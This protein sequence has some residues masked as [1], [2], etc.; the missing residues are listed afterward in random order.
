VTDIF[1]IVISVVAFLIILIVIIKSKH[2]LDETKSMVNLGNFFLELLIIEPF[3]FFIRWVPG[4]WGI[5]LR[6]V[7]YKFLFKEMGK[8]V[9]IMEGSKIFDFKNIEIGE[10]SSLNEYCYLI[11]NGSIKIGSWTRIASYVSLITVD[12]V[13]TDP[14]VKI[15]K[16]GL[17]SAP[18]VIGDDVWIGTKAT[19]LKGI[20]IGNG[21]VIGA[22]SVVTD[23]IPSFA[24]VAGVPAKII[25]LRSKP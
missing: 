9:V 7:I 18:I 6:Y 14:S 8:N 13:F 10:Y 25:S 2:H 22:G 17:V 4:G 20:T 21:A 5:F 23:D 15:K 3:I 11:G 19:I 24:V 12:H 16:Q 1:L